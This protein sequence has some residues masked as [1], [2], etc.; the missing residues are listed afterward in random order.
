MVVRMRSTRSHTGN[1]RSHHALKAGQFLT[2]TNC[3]ASKLPHAVCLNCG[4]YRGKKVIDMAA[5][6][7]KKAKKVKEK[8]K[9]RA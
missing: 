2:C 8:A 7:A 6:L 4:M 1:R 5:K 9:V 3:K